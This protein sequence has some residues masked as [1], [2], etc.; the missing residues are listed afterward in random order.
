MKGVAFFLT[1]VTVTFG[2][3]FAFTTSAKST[4]ILLLK[5]SLFRRCYCVSLV[6]LRLSVG[7]TDRNVG[8]VKER[9]L[10]A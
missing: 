5:F 1:L 10:A 3:Q 4:L 8:K 6:F 7:E 9:N 2:M